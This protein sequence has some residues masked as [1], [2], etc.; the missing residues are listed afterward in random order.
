MVITTKLHCS[1]PRLALETPVLLL[2][3]TSFKENEDKIGTYLPYLNHIKRENL[4]TSNI[5][6]EEPK[7][8]SKEYLTLR[9]SLEKNV[10]NL[11]INIGSKRTIAKNR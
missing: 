2:Y 9:K 4:Y 1:L 3:D 8:N 7:E 10:N 6:F 11:S 5:N